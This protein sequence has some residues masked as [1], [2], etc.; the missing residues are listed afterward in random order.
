VLGFRINLWRE[1]MNSNTNV[2]VVPAGNLNHLCGEKIVVQLE[3]VDKK[4]HCICR[5]SFY[6]KYLIIQ[7]PAIDHL[8]LVFTPDSKIIVRYL[9]DGSVYGFKTFVIETISKP[10]RLVFI[11]YPSELDLLS[12]RNHERVDVFIKSQLEIYDMTVPG[13]I[14]DLSCGGCLLSVTPDKHYSGLMVEGEDDAFITF[15][16]ENITITLPCKIVR[17]IEDATQLQLGIIFDFEEGKESEL[18]KNYVNHVKIF[19]PT[20]DRPTLLH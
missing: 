17:F 20:L 16:I 8:D 19:Y 2:T 10:Y 5:G 7:P 18:I 13:V 14:L 4:I 11:G 6:G 9:S 12:L 15:P 1:E 3:N